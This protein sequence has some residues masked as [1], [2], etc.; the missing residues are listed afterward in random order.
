MC[1]GFISEPNTSTKDINWWNIFTRDLFKSVK[2]LCWTKHIYLE[3]LIAG[4]WCANVLKILFNLWILSSSFKTGR[5]AKATEPNLPNTLSIVEDIHI[6]IW[7]GL[8]IGWFDGISSIVGYLMPNPLL[9]I[10]TVLF[11]TVQFIIRTLYSSLY[12]IDRALWGATT[13]G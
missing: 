11:Q 4:K 1:N 5:H 6:Y 7:R 8:L 3:E 2:V 10:E 13:P 9:Y 12:L